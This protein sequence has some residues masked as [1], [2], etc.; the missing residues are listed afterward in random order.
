MAQPPE[1]VAGGSDEILIAAIVS[2]FL[3]AAASA[4]ALHVVHLH[5]LKEM[6][7]SKSSSLQHGVQG[8]AASRLDASGVMPAGF[9]RPLKTRALDCPQ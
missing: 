1:I 8:C 9:I 4:Q 3:V 2:L 5:L 6:D 7:R